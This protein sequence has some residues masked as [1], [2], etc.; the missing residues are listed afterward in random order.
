MEISSSSASYVRLDDLTPAAKTGTRQPAGS[1]S[2]ARFSV[3]TRNQQVRRDAGHIAISIQ[4]RSPVAQAVEEA[5]PTFPGELGNLVSAYIGPPAALPRRPTSDPVY[6]PETCIQCL[7][8][9]CNLIKGVIG[10]AV[11][12][13][14]FVGVIYGMNH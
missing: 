2:L 9:C 14:V 1:A 7:D 3:P 5:I 12:F 13:G 10:C 6:N 11:V 8:N 4:N